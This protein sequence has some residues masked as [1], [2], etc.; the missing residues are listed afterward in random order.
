[1]EVARVNQLE[2]PSEEALNKFDEARKRGVGSI[3]PYASIQLVVKTSPTSLLAINV[4][5]SKVAAEAAIPYRE[6]FTEEN[7]FKEEW[8]MDGELF[9]HYVNHRAGNLIEE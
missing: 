2:F 9:Q 3:N 1:M 4:F 8:Y 6:K 5:T 7:G